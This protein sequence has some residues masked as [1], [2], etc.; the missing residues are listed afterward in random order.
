VKRLLIGLLAVS[1]FASSASSTV[2][3]VSPYGSDETGDGS[4]E[5]PYRTPTYVIDNDSGRKVTTGC[6]VCIL[7]GTYASVKSAYTDVKI[8]VRGLHEPIGPNG[9][10]EPIIDGGYP[11]TEHRIFYLNNADIVVENLTFRNCCARYPG[12]QDGSAILGKFAAVRNCTFTNCV[13]REAY[14]GGAIS[15]QG[16]CEISN[17]TF[18]ACKS[19]EP[20]YRNCSAL[21]VSSGTATLVDCKFK[22]CTSVGNS[23]GT[24]CLSATGV[25]KNCT[26]E[27]NLARTQAGLYIGGGDYDIS[28]CT[29]V[30]NVA[31]EGS[32][33]GI[34]IDGTGAA[35]GR[36][37]RCTFN[38]S[39]AAGNCA[40]SVSGAPAWIENCTVS[41]AVAGFATCLA[42]TAPATV[43]NCVFTDCFSTNGGTTVQAKTS[44]QTFI[45]CIIADNR[46]EY[47][48]NGEINTDYG[49]GTGV[50]FSGGKKVFRRC[51]ITN[52]YTTC[53]QAGGIYGEVT[54]EWYDCL[55]S[56]NSAGYYGG[57]T[58][59]GNGTIVSNCVFSENVARSGN[60]GGLYIQ[61]GSDVLITDC[62]FIGNKAPTSIAGALTA[63]AGMTCRNTLIVRNVSKNEPGGASIP[64]NSRWENCT[65]VGNVSSS[66]MCN[67]QSGD[68]AG[69]VFVNCLIA[70]DLVSNAA[71]FWCGGSHTLTSCI[72][73]STD[74]SNALTEGSTYQV[75]YGAALKLGED[76][77][78]ICQSSPCVDA[79]T[80][81]LAW[82]AGAKDLGG[83]HDRKIG[84][85]V[86][87][88]CY[89]YKPWIGTTL[90][91]K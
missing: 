4:L 31:T 27:H 58:I 29:F 79:G 59:R 86:D 63:P 20:A 32:G 66:G 36:I 11:L 6:T 60:C 9:E 62:A 40:L 12:N 18:V 91:L 1:V 83:R 46:V 28:D 13:M 74:L 34:T 54:S 90:Y 17:C 61:N 24:A 51:S 68:G 52:N 21:F 64:K 39:K 42:V 80:D 71:G 35:G 37:V 69:S 81:E 22:Y 2:I 14:H 8:T 3:Y 10:T 38:G 85:H 45:D 89:E 33:A 41:N 47:R 15:A 87:I 16:T 49:A 84:E 75:V 56:S 48:K 25:V 26:F 7:P 76:Y 50:W 23:S 77:R 57:G 88:G 55:V 78:P 43:T 73:A 53:W 67:L 5:N 44:E 70:K 65:V 72:L 82:I 30:D 19:I